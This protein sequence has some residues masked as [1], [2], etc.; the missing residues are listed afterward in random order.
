VYAF[1]TYFI[2]TC[3]CLYVIFGTCILKELNWWKGSYVSFKIKSILNIANKLAWCVLYAN[4]LPLLNTKVALLW[5]DI[6]LDYHR[7]NSMLVMQTQCGSAPESDAFIRLWPCDMTNFTLN[8]HSSYSDGFK[9]CGNKDK[10]IVIQEY[11]WK[12]TA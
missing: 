6:L 8:W 9:W 2:W 4:V 12:R 7:S 10:G 3:C 5:R 1:K 11:V